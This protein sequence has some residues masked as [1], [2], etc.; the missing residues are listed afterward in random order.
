MDV[1]V[2]D[3]LPWCQAKDVAVEQICKLLQ[4]ALNQPREE[5][6]NAT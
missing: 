2:A 6:H 3:V 4:V 1:K 5:A